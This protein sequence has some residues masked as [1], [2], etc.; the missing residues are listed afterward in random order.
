VCTFNKLAEK[1]T[2]HCG[3]NEVKSSG[4]SGF[5]VSSRE[6]K[7]VGQNLLGFSSSHPGTQKFL[8]V[9]GIFAYM[10]RGEIAFFLSSKVKC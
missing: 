8:Y 7:V 10:F 6:L 3:E 1:M 4:N 9:C 5:S 2:V